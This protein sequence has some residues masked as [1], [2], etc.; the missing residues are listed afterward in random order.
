MPAGPVDALL[1]HQT[2]ARAD[3]DL[4]LTADHFD[5][6]RA[7]LSR[8]ALL[9][10]QDRLATAIAYTGRDCDHS[11]SFDPSSSPPPPTPPE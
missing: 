5:A 1:G 8:A 4:V 10:L 6:A 7:L 9:V 3:L 2:R 11:A